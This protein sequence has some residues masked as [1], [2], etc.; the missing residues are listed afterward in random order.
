MQ[1]AEPLIPIVI[2]NW[3]GFEVTACC[4]EAL[5]KQDYQNFEIHLVDNGSE[6]E[7][8]QKLI[9]A[10]SS[11]PKV[12]LYNLPE[13]IGFAP[14]C[15]MVIKKLIAQNTTKFIA[16][17]N[18]DTEPKPLWLSSLVKTALQQQ[19]DMVAS[20]Q[21]FYDSPEVIDNTGLALLRTTE[22]LPIGAREKAEKYHTPFE[23]LCPSAGAGLYSIEVFKKAGLFNEYFKTCY[24]DA[25]L[26]LRAALMGF[27]T[28]YAPQAEVLHRVS[29]TINKVK[30]KNYGEILQ[31]N[32]VYAYFNLMPLRISAFTFFLAFAK[33]SMLVLTGLI[34]FRKTL[35][36]TQIKGWFNA[37]SDWRNPKIATIK[38]AKKIP[39]FKILQLHQPFIPFYFKYLNQFIIRRKPTILE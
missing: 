23:C 20:K 16:L 19:C 25:E 7:E 5:A 22:I 12:V 37:I 31:T 27:K 4:L 10:I 18:N 32:M 24:E 14:A 36:K 15:N 21:V 11:M 1:L 35:V 8:K 39:F 9:T 33:S 17:L 26:G 29:Y 38:P 13:N 6:P 3:N 30:Q 2:L 34:L 28:M